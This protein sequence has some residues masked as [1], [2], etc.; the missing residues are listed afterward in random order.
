MAEIEIYR[1]SGWGRGMNRR[2]GL[3]AAGILMISVMGIG[4]V[5]L[6]GHTMVPKEQ[7]Q[8]IP[9]SAMNW[10]NNGANGQRIVK[11]IG[12]HLVAPTQGVVLTDTHCN[13][14]AKG[15][16]HCHNVIRLK[17]HQTIKVIDT[18][19]IMHYGCLRIDEPVSV[20]PLGAS[21]ARVT[22]KM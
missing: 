12:G 20:T 10:Q 17:N 2:W 5:S 7:D 6:G 11:I 4:V 16:S 3:L 8:I 9:V 1:V 13:P 19:N 14:D 22:I 21:W 15:L 18:H